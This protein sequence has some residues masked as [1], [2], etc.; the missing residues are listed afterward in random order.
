MH[1]LQTVCTP[2]TGSRRKMILKFIQAFQSYIHSQQ[3]SFILE[4]NPFSPSWQ[5]FT[6]IL[7][8]LYGVD[9]TLHQIPGL[10]T[11]CN[12][13]LHK[14]PVLAT[15]VHSLWQLLYT[16]CKESLTLFILSFTS[17]NRPSQRTPCG[18]CAHL[19]PTHEE[20]Q[21]KFL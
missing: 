21:F 7:R 20:K 6:L 11:L 8:L 4:N 3:D 16:S 17:R 19:A 2:C 14:I 9:S 18:L 10:F 15:T 1:P 5:S 13:S 12:R